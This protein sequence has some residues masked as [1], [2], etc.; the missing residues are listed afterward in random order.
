MGQGLVKG[1]A[2][3]CQM[4]MSASLIGIS[5]MGPILPFV[6]VLCPCHGKHGPWI[7]KHQTYVMSWSY[8][9]NFLCRLIKI[10]KHCNLLVTQV[11]KLVSHFVYM[12]PIISTIFFVKMPLK[13][14]N[15]H[16]VATQLGCKKGENWK[17]DS[18]GSCNKHWYC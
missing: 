11:V 9:G 15:T 13:W 18:G 5:Y 4:C 6:S 12:A 8:W 17:Q 10:L 1:R 2:C 16:F 14:P 7:V 3:H